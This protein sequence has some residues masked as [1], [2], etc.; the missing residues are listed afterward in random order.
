MGNNTLYN[1]ADLPLE[2]LI[3]EIDTGAIGL[4][5]MQR[6]FVWK[7]AKIRD[8]LD[9]MIKGY[10]I[11][12]V[13]TWEAS[14]NSKSRQIG[15]TKH[16]YNDPSKLIIDG[17]QRLTSLYSIVKGIAVEGSD[18]KNRTITI[19][20]NPFTRC[21]EVGTPAL[22]KSSDW[23]YNITD[24]FQE[25][26]SYSSSTKFLKRLE[27]SRQ[28]N[29]ETVSDKEKKTIN[30]NITDLLDLKK[31]LIPTLDI[32]SAADEEDVSNI[33]VNINGSGTKLNE[34]DF[35]LTLISVHW[36]DGRDLIEQFCE[37]TKKHN[38]EGRKDIYNPI[39]DFDPADVIRAVMSFGFKRARLKYAYKLL[40]GADFDKKGAVSDELRAQRF[41]LFKKY[42][43]TT[44]N[45][46]NFVEFLK[47]VAAAG[48]VKKELISSK[49]NIIFSYTFYL[50][51]KYE[52]NLSE[53]E[54]R[55]V[56]TKAVFVF[57]L[58]SRYV[59]SF[60]S[61]MEQDMDNLPIEKTYSAFKDYFDKM[62]NSS[63]TDDFFNV[64]LIGMDGLETTN[65]RSPAFLAYIASQ[66]VLN[67]KVLFSTPQ[68]PTVTLYNEWA[69]GARKA[70]ELHHLFPKAYLKNS[71]SL[72]KKQINQVAN[73]AFI[74]W[75]ENMDILDAAPSVYFPPL[76]ANMSE[77]EVALME[78]EH[79]L[80][81]GWESLDYFEFLNLRRKNMSEII[82]KGYLKI[83][84]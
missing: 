57:A 21:F 35:I 65:N 43:D 4:P 47:C 28:K 79:G 27:E 15:Q 29:G 5:K 44:L 58:T 22:E 24:V 71:L 84:I 31:C 62:A 2:A 1:R 30:D 83:S 33:F 75:A 74:E 34:S 56:I 23:I 14:N 49:T 13:I 40:H 81:H 3:S 11:G 54:L 36:S 8:L 18:Y 20:F 6:Q 60:E 7:D 70:V 72:K 42:L 77:D 67:S 37:D 12:F 19:S 63:L 52:Y 64:T 61:Q 45:R 39:L 82:K 41:E 59:G 10:P 51:G 66:N 17:Q 25:G 46:D 26:S 16:G 9:S 69:T 68:I 76:I 53:P 55:S 32:I 48:Y 38:S 73:Y 80:P 78:A 50:I